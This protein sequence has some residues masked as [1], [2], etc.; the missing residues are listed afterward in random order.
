MAQAVKEPIKERIEIVDQPEET[1]EGGAR[2]PWFIVPLVL[3]LV[4]LGAFF[5]VRRFFASED[6]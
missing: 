5:V 2:A 4:A 3:L 6:E 1:S